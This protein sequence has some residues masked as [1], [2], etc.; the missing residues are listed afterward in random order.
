MKPWIKRTLI[1]FFGLSALFGGLAAWAHHGMHRWHAM[2]AEESAAMR[3]RMVD[4]VSGHLDL[5][6]A[7]KAKLGVLAEKIHQQRSA[8]V[9]ATNP[10]AEFQALIAG[11]SFDRTRAG[12]LLESKLSSVHTGAPEVINALGDFYDSLRPEQQAK[13]R[14]FMARGRHR[15]GA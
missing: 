10:R 3:A 7:Q 14:D 5:D 8:V 12:A 9:G 4:R 11:P 2:S 1:G 15:H 6:A 13:V